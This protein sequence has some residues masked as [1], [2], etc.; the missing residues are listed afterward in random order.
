VGGGCAATDA[1]CADRVPRGRDVTL[2]LASAERG[3]P[4]AATAATAAPSPRAE[5]RIA[6]AER[7]TGAPPSG[8]RRTINFDCA[9]APTACG[10]AEGG[11]GGGG[12]G[13]ARRQGPM[14][15]VS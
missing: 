13:R 3:G 7:R 15:G 14:K 4:A 1:A 8:R 9:V 11:E 12:G 10:M 5:Q 6:A 2:A